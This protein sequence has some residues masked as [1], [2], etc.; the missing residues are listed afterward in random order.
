MY[1][2]RFSYTL[3]HSLQKHLF[4]ASRLR[5]KNDSTQMKNRV[6]NFLEHASRI[7]RVS[8]PSLNPF[9]WL[10]FCQSA[11]EK[12][13]ALFCVGTGDIKILSDFGRPLLPVRPAA[14]F[15]SELK[16][17]F[18]TFVTRH[19]L[20]EGGSE[21][22]VGLNPKYLSIWTTDYAVFTMAKQKK[23]TMNI[24]WLN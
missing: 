11:R 2:K 24:R 15:Q 18:L 21:T 13:Y 4:Y 23:K 7:H 8:C 3:E 12:L 9:K 22:P 6:T 1:S 10:I 19:V 17:G 5:D 16:R 14:E 20:W